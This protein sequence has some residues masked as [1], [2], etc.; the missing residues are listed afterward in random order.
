MTLEFPLNDVFLSVQRMKT[1]RSMK[2]RMNTN[3]HFVASR[4]L[5][6]FQRLCLVISLDVPCRS[7]RCCCNLFSH[8]PCLH[9]ATFLHVVLKIERTIAIG[10][11][12]SYP[13][14]L[15][16]VQTTQF[17]WMITVED[18]LVDTMRHPVCYAM[19]AIVVIYTMLHTNNFHDASL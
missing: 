18:D 15:M 11:Y 7:W 5:R 8:R 14:R 17:N 1:T 16:L 4:F 2:F 9:V 13:V 3:V 10:C 6:G 12:W 19:H